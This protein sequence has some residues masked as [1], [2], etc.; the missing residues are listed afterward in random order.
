MNKMYRLLALPFLLA[1]CQ[2]GAPWL[3]SRVVVSGHNVR[4]TDCRSALCAHNENTDLTAW[5]GAMWLVHRT[6][7]SQ[8]LGPN[9]SLHVYRSTDAGR[10]FVPVARI[11]AP[12]DRDIR[13]PHFYV[14]GGELWIKAL[15]R[16]PVTSWRD[17][18]VDTI[19][20]AL[21]S[22]DGINWQA[23]VA[24]GPA[25]WS[26]WRIREQ[27]GTYYTAAYRDGDTEVALF[28][29]T[30]GLRWKE[31]APIYGV[32]ADTPLETELTFM[33]S[34][35]LLALVRMDGTDDELLGTNG[36]LRTKVCWASP[37]YDHFDCPQEVTGQRLDGPVTFLARNRLFVIARKHLTGG[38]KRTALYELQGDLDNGGTLTILERGEL[39]SAGDTSYAG[40]AFADPTHAIVSWYSGDTHVDEP[41]ILGWLDLSDIWVGSIDLGRLETAAPQVL[42][43]T[44]MR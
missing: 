22:H 40:V 6:A 41:W 14:V 3:T 4:N 29:S 34:G 36:R 11:E 26:F 32:A 13:D 30:D 25:G 39:P 23:P 42:R 16:L 8:V 43:S 20:V 18:N 44:A 2:G 19:A 9:S 7:R 33:P 27:A 37:P 21:R 10:T 24:I 35:R 28:S 38:R 5:N 31:I 1:A 12:P 17:A 15:T